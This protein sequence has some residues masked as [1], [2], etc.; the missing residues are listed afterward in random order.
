[1][2]LVPTPEPAVPLA[3]LKEWINRLKPVIC[4]FQPQPDPTDPTNE[5][6]FRSLIQ[7][8]T[9]RKV[10]RATWFICVFRSDVTT[11]RRSCLDFT[12]WGSGE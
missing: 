3:E 11:V 8:L 10:V 9:T 2:T 7:L 6:Y 5:Q 1:M 12:V 4:R